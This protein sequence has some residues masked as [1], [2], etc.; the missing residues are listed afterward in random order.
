MLPRIDA[1]IQNGWPDWAVLWPDRVWVIELKTEAASHRDAQLPYYLLLAAA[2]HP[3]AQVD[4]TY[5]TGPLTKPAPA[6]LMGQRYSHLTWEQILP[7][8]EDVWGNDARPERGA[9]VE[10][11]RTV[12]EHL[13]ILRPAE[14]RNFVLGQR[15]DLPPTI[16]PTV[17]ADVASASA[18]TPEF[19]SEEFR[20][21]RAAAD[22]L[23]SIARSTA[24]DGRQRGV[25]AVDPADLEVLRDTAR[26]RIGQLAPDDA[27]RF[28]LPWLW[29]RGNTGGKA[30][31]PEGEE[32]GY[33]LR[34]SRYKQMQVKP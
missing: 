9:Y 31:T 24:A 8:I 19:A 26:E 3:G 12:I 4:L 15:T 20:D 33:E 27:T 30:L 25:G 11:V 32:F 22:D 28:V 29:K 34:F 14:Q 6:L 21:R 23:L 13:N 7:L 1:G 5:I 17:V 18:G 16:Q 10:M 2:A